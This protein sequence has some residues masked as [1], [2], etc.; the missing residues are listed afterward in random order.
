MPLAK[1][2]CFLPALFL[3]VMHIRRIVG[4]ITRIKTPKE[5]SSF[6]L[7]AVGTFFQIGRVSN[8]QCDLRARARQA[9]LDAGFHPD[10]PVEI[11]RQLEAQKAHPPQNPALQPRDL[12]SVLWSSI[13]NDQSRDLDQIEFAE[14]LPDGSCRLLVGIADVDSLVP[15]GSAIDQ[16]AQSET[17]SVYTGICVFPML[18]EALSTNAT[19]LLDSQDRLSLVMEMQVAASGEVN[20][21][22]VYVASVCNKAKLTYNATGAWLEGRGPIPAPVASTPGMEQQLRLQLEV[23]SCLRQFRKQQGA[24]TFGSVETTPIIEGNS[25]TDLQDRKP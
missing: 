15:K 2:L 23:A 5:P 19:S 10:F 20:H 3:L 8:G 7:P 6:H 12:R 13:D 18:P 24:L 4:N 25:V 17:T 14:K 22:Q 21:Q 9:M 16:H 11:S 1:L